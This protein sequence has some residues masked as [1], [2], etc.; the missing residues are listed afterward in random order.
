MR[1]AL[2]EMCWVKCSWWNLHL[3]NISCQFE[4][5]HLRE[6]TCTWFA[7]VRRHNLHS[8]VLLQEKCKFL[9]AQ[10]C[11]S[12]QWKK[13]N[14]V[15]NSWHQNAILTTLSASHKTG[16]VLSQFFIAK[17]VVSAAVTVTHSPS[18]WSGWSLAHRLKFMASE[19]LTKTTASSPT[20]S[21]API[22]ALRKPRSPSRSSMVESFCVQIR[23]GNEQ[24]VRQLHIVKR[25]QS[26]HKIRFS[27]LLY[28][29][30]T[31]WFVSNRGRNTS[32][33][34]TSLV[35]GSARKP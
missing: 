34:D 23:K 21:L 16:S 12:L 24:T 35:L 14:E 8:T 6:R 1:R 30:Q 25:C 5:H 13:R 19:F 10:K 28:L 9:S 3:S 31:C 17:S 27:T 4:E 26:C 2:A 15:L 33:E 11:V 7:T 32:R 20:K 22:Q 18:L 29:S